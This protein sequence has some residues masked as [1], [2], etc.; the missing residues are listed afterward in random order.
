MNLA[1]MDPQ[2][3]QAQ[4]EQKQ[5]ELSESFAE[6]TPPALEVF[7]SE[8]ANYRMRAEFRV[9]HDGEDLYY[10]MFDKALNE[11]VR[12]EQYLPAGKLINDM[13]TALMEELRPNR[14]LRWKLFQ[15]DFLSTLSGEI[16]VSLLYH[17]QLDDAWREQA[18]QM[19]QRLSE[20]FNVNFIGRAR[21]QK[22][23]L[24]KDYVVESLEVDG[25]TLKYKQIENSFTQP[26]AKVSVKM[27]EWAIDV[28]NNST[29]DLLELYCGN[30]NFSIAL[31]KNFDRVLATELAKP[32]VDAAQ[33][34]I[35][36][37]NV[38][39]LQIIRMSAEDFS[40]AMA[41]KRKFRRL[42]GIDLDS[43]NCNT[44][45]VDPPRAGIDDDTLALMQNYDRILYISCNPETLKD[46]LKVLSTTHKI[47]RFALFD[48]FPY[49]HHMESGVLLERK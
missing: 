46:N 11:K 40:D 37:N 6:F 5:S 33:Y 23:D 32:S 43:Y 45:F 19:K 20:R 42:E 31:A 49:T 16:L 29:G 36:E 14:D 39:N 38:D 12:T 22:I 27:L 48:Q 15:V 13:M 28:T 18:E 30:G 25:Q 17:R 26:N 3:Y 1:A 4:L 24:D 2:N 35:A 7:A 8:P 47:S 44:I 9:W 21:K 34:N 10:Y 41:K